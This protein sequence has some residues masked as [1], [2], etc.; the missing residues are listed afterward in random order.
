MP[1]RSRASFVM[2]APSSNVVE[3]GLTVQLS[4]STLKNMKLHAPI[5]GM[6]PH[7]RLAAARTASGHAAAPSHGAHPRAKDVR[8]SIAGFGNDFLCAKILFVLQR[9]F[10]RTQLCF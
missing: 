2:K 6:A 9:Q 1:L 4:E 7:P 3:A 10:G 5:S 8:S